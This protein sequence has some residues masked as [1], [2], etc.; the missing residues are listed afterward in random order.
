LKLVPFDS[1][2]AVSYSPSIVTMALSCL[3][4]EIKP[5]R[6]ARR[7]ITIPF[8]TEKLEWWGYPAVKNL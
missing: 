5:A 4:P 6:G 1:L 2:V 7:N 3:S 8:G